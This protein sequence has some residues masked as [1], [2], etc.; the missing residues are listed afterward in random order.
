MKL[1]RSIIILTVMSVLIASCG[2]PAPNTVVAS[3]GLPY[4]FI[5]VTA[6]IDYS[7]GGNSGHVFTVKHIDTGCYYALMIG[8]YKGAFTQMFVEK[9]GVS[10]PY[11]EK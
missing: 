7:T 6:P 2:S 1:L 10:V 9:N 11:C 4:G 8:G 3:S 5:Q